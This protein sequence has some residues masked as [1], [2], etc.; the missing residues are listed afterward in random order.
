MIFVL[1]CLTSLGISRSIHVAANGII[2]FFYG[3]VAFQCVCVCIYIYIY[4]CVY[5]HI[6][7]CV[8]ISLEKSLMLGWI[9]GRRRRGRQRMRWLDGITS[10]MDVS[11]SE[12]RELVMDREAWRTALHGVAKSWT[13]LSDWTDLNWTVEAY[14]PARSGGEETVGLSSPRNRRFD[15]IHDMRG[16]SGEKDE[17]ACLIELME[18]WQ[19]IKYR[20]IANQVSTKKDSH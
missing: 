6:Y 16:I 11:L 9:G 2:S 3:W 7:L 14:C 18:Y 15:R 13:Q 8:F 4:V 20:D 17:W 5:T 12:L 1:L 19:G 10:S